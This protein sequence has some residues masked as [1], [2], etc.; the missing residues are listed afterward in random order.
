MNKFFD[1][2]RRFWK[3]LNEDS[4]KSWLVSLILAFLIIK[5]IF[6]PTLGFATGSILPL[7]VVESCSMYHGTSNFDLWWEQNSAWYESRGINKT[8]F[9]DF[10][11]KSGLN[12]G[13]IVLVYGRGNYEVGDIIIFKS[14]FTNPIIHRMIDDGPIAT[15]GDNNFGQLV[16][17]RNITEDKIIGKAAARV[18]GLGWIKLIFFEGTRPSEQRGFC[19]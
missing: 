14:D 10:S 15:K 12:K 2:L 4:W 18:P 17:E 1:S 6:F 5:F 3:F 8:D 13:D 11:F 16:Q 19:R 7:V 9:E